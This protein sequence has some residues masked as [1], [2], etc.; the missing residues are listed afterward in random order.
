MVLYLFGVTVNHS[1]ILY[2]IMIIPRV[3]LRFAFLLLAIDRVIGV[4]LPYRHRKIMTNRVVYTLITVAWL[5][6]AATTFIVRW[7][8]STVLFVP[9]FATLYHHLTQLA[10][11]RS[12]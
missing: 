2:V 8:S 9:P 7:T 3:N 6:A 10:L 4:S 11:L 5:V 12:C 1:D